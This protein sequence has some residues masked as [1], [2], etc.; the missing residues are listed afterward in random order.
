MKTRTTMT[1]L[2]AMLARPFLD[3]FRDE[4]SIWT[5]KPAAARPVAV[6]APVLVIATPE[7]APVVVPAAPPVAVVPAVVEVTSVEPVVITA[8]VAA[9]VAKKTRTRKPAMAMAG[10]ARTTKPRTR[11]KPAPEAA[12]P[13]EATP[14]PI[15][16]APAKAFTVRM[17]DTK[18][19]KDWSLSYTPITGPGSIAGTLSI[20]SKRSHA[21]YAVIEFSTGWEGRGFTLAKLEGGTDNAN[22]SYSVFCSTRGPEAD[23]CDCKGS[24][25]W[26]HCK[27]RRALRALLLNDKL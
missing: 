23:S 20:D 19:E 13:L 10:A 4:R 3:A 26:D 15:L 17:A 16:A 2:F 25:R 27:H 7:P 22:E 9:A 8:P 18:A 21:R 11:T 12:C 24:T 14:E 6:V 5:R 1:G